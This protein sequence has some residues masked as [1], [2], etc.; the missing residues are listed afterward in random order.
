[1]QQSADELS[2]RAGREGDVLAVVSQSG[3]TVCFFD[4]ATD[5]LLD[6]VEVTA[7]PHE[8]CFDPTRRLLWCASTYSSGYYHDNAGRRTELTV[9]DPDTRRV[10][11]VVDIAPEHG[12]HGIALDAARGRL[13]VSVEGS[14]DRP[15]GVV[16]I[17][18]ESRKPL[19]RIDTDAPGPHWFA[20][21][22]AGTIGYATN[23][24]AP[25]VSVVDLERGTLTAKIEV[26]GSEGLAVSADGTHAFVAAPYG[27]FAPPRGADGSAAAPPAPGIR[28]VDARTASVTAVLPAQSTVFPVHLTSTGL[29]LAGELRMET[30]PQ[31]QLG[32]QAPGRLLV[33]SAATHEA[34]GEVEVGLFPLTITSSP[35]GRLGYVACVVSSTVDVVDLETL[36]VLARLDVPRRGEAGAHGLA[37]VPRQA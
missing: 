2:A 31:S 12:P 34:V 7:Q 4:A 16:V 5:L 3:P 13:Y 6:T 8:L 25:F 1:M 33:Y 20:I 15:G 14:D 28:V 24:E 26:P 19:G 29:L 35:D 27:S 17:D 37:Y 10:V 22:P 18:T 11:D 36:R 32:R 21:D 23:K 30:D 9:I